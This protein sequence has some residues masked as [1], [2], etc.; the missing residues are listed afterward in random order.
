MSRFCL[1]PA[2]LKDLT[3][4]TTRPAQAA[5]LRAM[6]IPFIQDEEDGRI[7]VLRQVAEKLGGIS[8]PKVE[9]DAE[10]DFEWMKKRA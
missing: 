4:R 2:E 7:K 8:K 3:D 9:A 10:P 5:R 6:R 1:T